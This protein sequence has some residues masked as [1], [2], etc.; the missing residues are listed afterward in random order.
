[1]KT[2]D[3]I[4]KWN[5]A[6]HP[7]AVST[8]LHIPCAAAGIRTNKKDIASA[9]PLNCFPSALRPQA[10]SRGIEYPFRRRGH[11]CSPSNKDLRCRSLF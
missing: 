10:A 6:F 1:M 8:G 4:V 3:N 2:T 7:Q 11:P 5:C 9:M